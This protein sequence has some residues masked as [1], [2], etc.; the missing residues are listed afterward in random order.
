[1]GQ[2]EDCD[3]SDNIFTVVVVARDCGYVT[4]QGED[5]IRCRAE[6][7]KW[8][9]SVTWVRLKDIPEE[10]DSPILLV[11]TPSSHWRHSSHCGGFDI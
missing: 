3:T 11:K 8:K 2:H 10:T 1:M 4:Q 9:P 5:I 6:M 7:G